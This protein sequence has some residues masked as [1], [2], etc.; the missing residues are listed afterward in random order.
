MF[1][2]IILLLL[3]IFLLLSTSYALSNNDLKAPSGLH[4]L[5]YYDFV[6]EKGHNIQIINYTD[7]THKTWFEND[8]GYTVQPYEK[9]N[10]FYLYA[11]DENDCGV[12]E[13][14]EYDGNKYIINSWTPNGS[15]D[16]ENV[17]NNLM[18][19]NKLNHLTPIPIK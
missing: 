11:D 9:N 10:S 15:K 19:F 6:D 7:N 12:L 4:K 2:K 17:V 5:G 16:A 14:I 18:E 8:T 1:K 13:I 3:L